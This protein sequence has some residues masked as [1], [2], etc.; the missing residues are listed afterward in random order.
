MVV[1]KYTTPSTHRKGWHEW[2][3]FTE[4]SFSVED[5]LAALRKKYP[6]ATVHSIQVFGADGKMLK[7]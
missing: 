6:T 3:E 5:T 1:I 7:P 4:D 2:G